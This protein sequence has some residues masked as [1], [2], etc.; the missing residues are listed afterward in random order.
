V[1]YT[2]ENIID[3]IYAKIDS[4]DIPDREKYLWKS[5]LQQYPNEISQNI[6]EW[7][8]DLPI[9]E[10]DCHGE[11]IVKTMTVW[12]LDESWMPWVIDGFI[13]FKKSGFRVQS[14]IDQQIALMKSDVR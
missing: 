2:I 7:I 11:S 6:L 10:V 14:V 3:G 1:K 9:T 13:K 4:M 12:D 8:N 5:K